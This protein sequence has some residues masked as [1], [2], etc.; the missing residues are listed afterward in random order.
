M[1][2]DASIV[3]A[4]GLGEASCSWIARTIGAH[5]QERLGISWVNIAEAGIVLHRENPL[6]FQ[7]LEPLLAK[8]GMEPLDLGWDVVR[9]AVEAHRRFPLNFGDCFAYAHASLTGDPLLTLDA[10]FFKTDLA[11]VLHPD[12]SRG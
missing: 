12:R 6:A 3:V 7:A 2:V 9:A 1:I 10:D 8:A 5:A 4:L 11:E